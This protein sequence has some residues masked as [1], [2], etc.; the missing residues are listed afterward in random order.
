M[1]ARRVRGFTLIEIIITLV[2]M[3]IAAAMVS[4]FAT[5]GITQASA[6]MAY[7]QTDVGLQLVMENMIDQLHELFDN[8]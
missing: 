4:T 7:L 5:R 1:T 3:G 6:P 8:E 2:L